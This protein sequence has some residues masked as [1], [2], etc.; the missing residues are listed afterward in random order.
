MADS[1]TAA[2]VMEVKVKFEKDT[3]HDNRRRFREAGVCYS[4]RMTPLQFRNGD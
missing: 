1:E 4:G 2:R 3:S